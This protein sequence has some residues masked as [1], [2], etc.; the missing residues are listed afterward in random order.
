M[1]DRRLIHNFDWVLLGLVVIICA[2]G[3]V[4]LYSAGYNRGEGTPLYIKQLYWLAVG[5]G[6]MC[7]TLTYDY[8]HLEKLSYPI[9]LISIV[10]LVAVMF[11]GKMVSG[12]RRWL[13]MGPLAFQPAELAKIGI[14]LAMSTYFNR[15]ARIEAMG[16]KDLIVPGALVMIPVALIIK[17]PDLGSGILVALVAGSIILF[18]GVRWRTLMGCGLTLVM[19]S[20]LLWHFLKDYQRQRVLTFLDPGRDPLGAG[21]HILQ[22]MIAVGS[23]QFWGKGFLQGTQSQLY[24]LPEQHTDFVFSVFAE[25]WGF[26]GSAVLLLLFTALALWGLSVARD[27]KERFGHLLAVGVT[28]LIFWQ[29]FINLC[30]VT[31]FLPVVGIPLP[32]FSYGGSSLITTLLGVGFLLNIR[33]RRYLFVG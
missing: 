12:S 21:Y 23:G 19:L 6:V 10:L 16:L 17:Q 3:I 29:I 24:F 8:R 26:V 25:E 27:C 11:G 13:P 28:A 30:M 9:Y 1:F 7:L 20:P 22:S 4:N 18:V 31:G 32:L 15:R 14:I 33:M 5:L 2:T